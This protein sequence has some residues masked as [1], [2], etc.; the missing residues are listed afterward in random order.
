[1]IGCTIKVIQ[2]TTITAQNFG[3]G[4]AKI[5]VNQT[6]SHSSVSFFE[7]PVPIRLLGAGGQTFD[8][9]VNNTTNGQQ[10]II[11]GSVCGNWSTI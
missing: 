11:L 1:M 10:F 3:A 5:T 8:T 6:Q 2:R 9:V 4:Q 7:M